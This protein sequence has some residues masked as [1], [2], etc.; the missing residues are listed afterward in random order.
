MTKSKLGTSLEP[1][2][3]KKTTEL[4][5][6]DYS[7]NK[8]KP[9][10]N[11]KKKRNFPLNDSG[12]KGLKLKCVKSTGNKFFVQNFWFDGR[13]D[14]WTVGVVLTGFLIQS[15]VLFMMLKLF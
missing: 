6:T 15:V 4:K 12:I 2:G 11:G 8:F 1:T 14:Y 13:A 9:D 5:F 10:Y 7:I 3:P